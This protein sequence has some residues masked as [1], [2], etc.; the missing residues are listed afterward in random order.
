[1]NTTSSVVLTGVV[2]SAGQW[3]QN[4]TVNI[5]TF[6]GIGVLAVSLA[7]IGEV[8]AKL[9]EQFGLL[10]LVAAILYYAIPI[11][12]GLGYYKGGTGVGTIRRAS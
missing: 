12:K 10:V 7:A 1:V 8:N 6:V 4:K 11:A 5:Q 2:T 9:A 3:A